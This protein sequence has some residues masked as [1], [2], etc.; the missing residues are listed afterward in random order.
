MQTTISMELA[1]LTAV[2]VLTGSLWMPYIVDRVFEHG[3]W[4]AVQNPDHDARPRAAWADRLMWAHANAVENLTIFAPLVLAVEV[5]GLHSP[6]TAGA[7]A[8][9]FVA[10]LA[11]AIIYTAGVP[12]LRTL[13]F[14]TGFGAQAV[15]AARVLGA[16]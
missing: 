9:Y 4:P 2:C 10:R 6:V 12:L 5:A 13:A 1:W 8:T 3:F 7:C 16:V 15:L 14:L 11:H